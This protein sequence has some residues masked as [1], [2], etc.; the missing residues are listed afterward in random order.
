MAYFTAS[1]DDVED[2]TKFAESLGLDLPDPQRSHQGNGQG[3]RRGPRGPAGG[4]RWTFYIGPDGKV[5]AV[6]QKVNAA[7]HAKDIVK[8]LEE[9]GVKKKS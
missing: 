9:L 2:N 3:L 5:K 6:D 7:Q 8:Q 1:V 4:Q